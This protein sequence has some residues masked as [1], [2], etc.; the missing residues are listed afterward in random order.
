MKAL[1]VALL[2]VATSARAEVLVDAGK[3]KLERTR[4]KQTDRKVARVVVPLGADF[5]F[6]VPPGQKVKSGEA[7]VLSFPAEK[8][9]KTIRRTVAEST[10]YDILDGKGQVTIVFEHLE[11]AASR[12]KIGG[13]AGVPEHVHRDEAEILYVISGGGEMTVDGK[14]VTVEAGKAYHIPANTKHSFIATPE[15][16]AIQFYVPGGPE[17]RFKAAKVTK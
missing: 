8:G 2:L 4:P 11:A 7:L 15:V 6:W 16:E 9:K 10:A 12:L 1:V 17:Q 13:G 3:V 14:K 5:M